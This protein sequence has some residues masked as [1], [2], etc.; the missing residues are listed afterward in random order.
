MIAAFAIMAAVAANAA[1]TSWS[2][3]A[4]KIITTDN[5]ATTY[6]SSGSYAVLYASLAGEGTWFKVTDAGNIS[7]SAGKITASST[8]FESQ[9]FDVGS[10]YDFYFQI[11]DGDKTFTSTTITGKGAQSVTTVALDFGNQKTAGQT[12]QSVPEPTSGLLLLLGMA[13]LAL[14]RKRA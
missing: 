5:V 6:Y 9:L 2:V 4:T 10:N 8:S 12:W 7:I 1:A 3:I 13:G 14:K 11:T